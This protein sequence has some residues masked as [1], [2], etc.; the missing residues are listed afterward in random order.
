MVNT[1]VFRKKNKKLYCIEI[2]QCCDALKETVDALLSWGW[3]IES[4]IFN[5]PFSGASF[6]RM[7]HG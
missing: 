3:K 2:V 7:S 6:R 1:I 4:V 5:V